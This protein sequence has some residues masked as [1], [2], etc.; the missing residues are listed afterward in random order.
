MTL[1]LVY[2]KLLYTLILS[3]ALQIV[4]NTHYSPCGIFLINAK[5]FTNNLLKEQRANDNG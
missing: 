4:I 1:T 3:V 2:K 5:H